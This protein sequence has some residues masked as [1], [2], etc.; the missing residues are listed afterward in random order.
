LH[1][2]CIRC[3]T[4]SNRFVRRG[5]CKNCARTVHEN[6]YILSDTETKLLSDMATV[7]CCLDVRKI[8]AVAGEQKLNSA[9]V[10]KDF[11]APS[12]CVHTKKLAK[13][14][15]GSLQVL[16]R[17]GLHGE[18]ERAAVRTS[19]HCIDD[20]TYHRDDMLSSLD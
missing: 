4:P 17:L 15:G 18:W 10:S 2:H 7:Q 12:L 1:A 16:S 6:G 14:S 19:G 20:A 9:E 3:K 11:I 5:A 13:N 8:A